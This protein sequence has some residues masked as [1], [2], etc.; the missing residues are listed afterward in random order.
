MLTQARLK[1]LLDYDPSTGLFTW[2]V[3]RSGVRKGSSA[4]SLNN[5]GYMRISI[6][7]KRYQ[8]HIVAFL[9]M[10]GSFPH[11]EVDHMNNIRDDNRWE[12]LREAS[13]YQ[14]A[15]NTKIRKDNTSGFKGVYW[16][17][18]HKKWTVQINKNKKTYYHL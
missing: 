2:K 1:E 14:N 5:H 8:S 15:K 17:K 16:H 13:K 3:G 6:D 4:G 12:N 9:Y 10:T 11:E 18:R 7:G